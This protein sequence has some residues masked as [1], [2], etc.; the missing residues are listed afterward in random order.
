MKKVMIGVLILIPVIILLVL[1]AVSGIVS[2]AT[3]IGVEEVN[4]Y[5]RGT[6][7][8]ADIIILEFKNVNQEIQNFYNMVDVQVLP[9]KANYYSIEFSVSNVVCTDDDYTGDDPVYM[10][11][12]WKNNK[13]VDSNTTGDVEIKT[14]CY[15]TVNVKVETITKSFNVQV[16]GYDVKKITL[17]DKN[18]M[19]SSTMVV[20]QSLLLYPSYNPI[21]SIIKETTWS[22][23]DNKVAT[24]DKNGVINA[25]SVGTATIKMLTYAYTDTNKTKPVVSLDFTVTVEKGAST[26]YGNTVYL[27]KNSASM[28]DLGISEYSSYTGCDITGTSI[29]NI[30][31]GATIVVAGKTLT[32]YLINS[33]KDIVIEN[34]DVYDANNDYVFE[35]GDLKLLLSAIY[36]KSAGSHEPLN[37]TWSS[38]NESIAKVDSNGAVTALKSGLVTITATV[39]G[40]QASLKLNIQNKVVSMSLSSSNAYMPSGLAMETVFASERFNS[41]L[42]TTYDFNALKKK[43]DYL[44]SNEGKDFTNT[45]YS[46]VVPNYTLIRIDGE[47]QGATDEELEAFYSA[48]KFE[49]V[50]GQEYA[51]FS[52]SNVSN[53][54]VFKSALEGKGKQ[55]IQIKVSAKYPKYISMTKFTTAYANINAIYGVEVKDFIELKSAS[56][57]QYAYSQKEGNL[58]PAKVIDE[59]TDNKGNKYNVQLDEY[60]EKTYAISMMGN[61]PVPVEYESNGVTVKRNM[62]DDDGS[63]LCIYGDLYGNNNRI[64]AIN[65]QIGHY[66]I[67][68]CWSNIT[69]SNVQLRAGVVTSDTISKEE[70]SGLDSDIME[71]YEFKNNYY[72]YHMTNVSVEY[73]LFENGSRALNAFN[74]DL[75]LR[76]NVFRN[77]STCCCHFPTRIRSNDASNPEDMIYYPVY[78]HIT[79]ENCVVSNTLASFAVLQYDFFSIVQGSTPTNHIYRFA[80]TEEENEQFI[81]EYFVNKGY[82]LKFNQKGFLDVYN[83]APTTSS[84]IIDTKVEELNSI[85]GQYAGAVFDNNTMFDNARYYNSEDGLN[86][87]SLVFVSNGVSDA[88]KLLFNEPLYIDFNDGNGFEDSRIGCAELLKLS[89]DKD[90]NNDNAKAVFACKALKGLQINVG[91]YYY[92]NDSGVNPSDTFKID[93]NSIN[94][95]HGNQN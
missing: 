56:L 11:D 14:Y 52:D 58:K 5:V 91:L 64:S 94:R 95:I 90:Q 15:F 31:N 7:K 18:N 74:T 35:V 51:E 55:Q 59:F 12:I 3:A 22:S 89:S 92:K 45:L 73:S 42:S 4:L 39:D 69:C 20:G 61:C 84:E 30:T 72:M 32:I 76:G 60:S 81:K 80:D 46:Y 66:L 47:P 68:L 23:S 65:G 57:I 83:W 34:S 75:T 67:K 24:V 88:G 9:K 17:K 62:Y 26:L 70:T 6:E 36:R 48:Y 78:D 54:L 13:K 86:Y 49:V 10:V 93:Q 19:D 53:K 40:K 27:S 1:A 29:T 63:L 43:F 8:Q 38:S 25:K 16:V 33:D 50:V 87:F 37:A 28:S 85:V 82:N 41:N 21:E 2:V 71:I 79:T 44:D 77:F